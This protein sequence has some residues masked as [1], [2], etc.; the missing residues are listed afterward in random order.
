M[1][2]FM[3]IL[4]VLFT[5]SLAMGTAFSEPEFK[6]S[7]LMATANATGNYYSFGSAL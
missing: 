7:Y 2:R 3:F 1:K 4:C 5:L 6:G